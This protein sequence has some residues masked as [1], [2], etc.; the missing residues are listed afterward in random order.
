MEYCHHG[1]LRHYLTSQHV[2]PA[3]E[4]QQITYQILEGLDQMHQNGFSH[5]DLKPGV[6][7]IWLLSDYLLTAVEHSHQVNATN[8]EVVDSTCRL[9]N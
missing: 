9:W 7:V 4:V 6:S 3:T 8:G 1:D 5:R 2:V